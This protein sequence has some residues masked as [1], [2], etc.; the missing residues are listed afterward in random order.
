MTIPIRHLDSWPFAPFEHTRDTFSTKNPGLSAVIAASPTGR[1]C[2]NRDFRLPGRWRA[3]S[4]LRVPL[5]NRIRHL[6]LAPVTP[7]GH[8]PLCKPR[9]L[10]RVS[11]V[12]ASRRQLCESPASSTPPFPSGHRRL[13]EPSPPAPLV[14]AATVSCANPWSTATA[15]SLPGRLPSVVQIPGHAPVAPGRPPSV[16]RIR[17]FGSAA[18]P[19][20]PPSRVFFSLPPRIGQPGPSSANHT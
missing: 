15:P 2:S 19:G 13:C 12:P 10:R 5:V 8:R 9:S 18:R 11:V 4:C 3:L 1:C 7:G 6:A 20:R 16:V 17:R 14:L